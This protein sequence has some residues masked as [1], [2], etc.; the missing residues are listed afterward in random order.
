MLTY[1][2]RFHGHGS[3]RY[4]YRNGQ[5]VRTSLITVKYIVN[6][7][8]KNSRFSV[9]ISKKVMKSAVRRN[10]LRRQ[11]YEIIRQEIPTLKDHHDVAVMVFSG[12]AF[13]TEYTSLLKMMKNIFSQAGL[14]K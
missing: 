7:R 9:I 12:E 13:S 4:V 8:R 14:Y 10:R 2:N 5:S 1:K 6:P 3:L 11:I